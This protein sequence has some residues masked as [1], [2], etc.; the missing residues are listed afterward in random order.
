MDQY[1]I[2]TIIGVSIVFIL[3]AIRKLFHNSD[4]YFDRVVKASQLTIMIVA[5]ITYFHTIKPQYD[6]QKLK[7]ENIS[8]RQDNKDL[9]ESIDKSKTL[10]K[11]YDQKI[12]A[13]KHE[14]LN[15]QNQVD[16]I[17]NE[18]SELNELTE[19]V[20]FDKIT[21]QILNKYNY[22]ILHKKPL[23]A[24]EIVLQFILEL[25]KG[26]LKNKE[27]EY[28]KSYK[29]FVS[30]EISEKSSLFDLFMSKVFLFTKR[31]KEKYPELYNNESI[32]ED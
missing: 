32:K 25:E 9:K 17:R 2:Y 12:T 7:K 19:E 26:D 27:F 3:A 28:I 4:S 10:Q 31:N 21:Y 15:Y 8:L 13:L 16:S 30:N 22:E 24:K 6:N 14:K 18:F 20:F 5:V 29:E 23:N 11:Q 1:I